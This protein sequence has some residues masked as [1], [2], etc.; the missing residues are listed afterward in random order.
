MTTD[1]ATI[2]PSSQA[3]CLPVADSLWQRCFWEEYKACKSR[4]EKLLSFQKVEDRVMEKAKMDIPSLLEF[5]GLNAPISGEEF[6]H[7]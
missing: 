4:G 7:D 3:A 5:L 6:R 1:T 2:E